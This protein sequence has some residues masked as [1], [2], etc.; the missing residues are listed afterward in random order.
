MRIRDFSARRTPLAAVAV[1][2]LIGL[3]GCYVTV[4]AASGETTVVKR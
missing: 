4:D 1:S 2:L 3:V